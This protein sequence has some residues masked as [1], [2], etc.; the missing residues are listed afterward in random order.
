MDVKLNWKKSPKE[1]AKEKVGGP[2][3][4]AVSG[5]SGSRVHGS[6]CSGG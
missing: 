5:E 3:E 6:V 4:Y 2:G 1:I